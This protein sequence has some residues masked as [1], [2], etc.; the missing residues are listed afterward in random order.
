V[1]I[2]LEWKK[3]QDKNKYYFLPFIVPEIVLEAPPDT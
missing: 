3:I 2:F 1:N